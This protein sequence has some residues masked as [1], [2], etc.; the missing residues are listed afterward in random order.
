MSHKLWWWQMKERFFLWSRQ[1]AVCVPKAFLDEFQCVWRLSRQALWKLD[2]AKVDY[3]TNLICH[4]LPK[5]HSSPLPYDLV[6]F[7]LQFFFLIKFRDHYQFHSDLRHSR[8]QDIQSPCTL[9]WISPN[10]SSGKSDVDILQK[11]WGPGQ[12][13]CGCSFL[14]QSVGG[15][16]GLPKVSTDTRKGW[17]VIAWWA[18]KSQISTWPIWPLP[19]AGFGAP[20]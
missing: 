19:G 14:L 1:L 9:Y 17:F 18:V 6:Q 15:N 3:G 20:S 16:S 13:K 5:T 8:F 11:G 2:S 10:S 4:S 12:K 7:S